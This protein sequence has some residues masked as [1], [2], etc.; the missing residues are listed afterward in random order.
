MR[1]TQESP[2]RR[3]D[4]LR[5]EAA[6]RVPTGRL[7]HQAMTLDRRD[8]RQQV[9]NMELDA[10]LGSEWWETCIFEALGRSPKWLR[11]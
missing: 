8:S 11:P 5:A 9:I 6:A 2:T 7:I 10:R 4:R 3:Y 1:T